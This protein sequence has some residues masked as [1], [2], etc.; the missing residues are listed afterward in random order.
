MSM[1]LSTK[2]L[3]MYR[4]PFLTMGQKYLKKITGRPS[5]LGDV[6]V[7]ISLTMLSNSSSVKVRARLMFPSCDTLCRS[8]QVSGANP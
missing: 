1:R 8:D 5:G 7:Y 4:I 3:R 6:F 2:S